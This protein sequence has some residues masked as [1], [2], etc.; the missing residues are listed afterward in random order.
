MHKPLLVAAR[1]FASTVLTKGFLLGLLLAPV[2]GAIAIGAMILVKSLP[3]PR[4]TGTVAVI[5]RSGLAAERIA[6][7]FTP[8]AAAEEAKR[9]AAEQAAVA[10]QAADRLG[11]D[12]ARVEGAMG[13]AAAQA[14]RQA[15]KADLAVEVL[16]SDADA[17][18]AKAPL[19][20]FDRRAAAEGTSRQ[21][22]LVAVIPEAAV[23]PGPDGAYAG[24]E[25]FVAPRLDFEVQ[26]RIKRRIADA[27][28]DTRIAEHPAVRAA[29]LSPETVRALVRRP[30]P[31]TIAVTAEGERRDAGPAQMMVPAAFMVLLLMSVM[32]GG[33]SLLSSTVEEKSSRVMEVLLSAVSPVQLMFGKILGQMAA[34]L[35]ILGMYAGVGLGAL[36]YF[37][38]KHLVSPMSLVYLVV[39]FFIAFFIIASM[40]AAVGSAV[41]DI[42]EAQTLQTPIVLIVILPWLLWPAISRAPNSIFATVLSFVPGLNPFVMM[43][44]LGGSEPV[45]AWQ[46]PASI[47][48]GV[49]T[50]ALAVWAA[51]KVF[52]IGV[53]MYGKPPNLATLIRWVRLA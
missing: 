25:V 6:K 4:V 40:M 43:I 53:L 11:V 10:G 51:A 7:Q 24:Y 45:P 9:Q 37:S 39:F 3:G 46:I 50:A 48:V 15:V 42:R 29:G 49:A 16:P 22:L 41:S 28:L 47:A 38:L 31:T 12:R 17:E 34:A 44:R 30:E 21:R 13:A 52:R 14:Q 2:L 27:V 36:V 5:D 1:E 19:A 33:G 20:R 32:I 18:Q 35:L 8:E 26:E 23:R